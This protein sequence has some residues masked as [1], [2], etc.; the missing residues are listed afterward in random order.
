MKQILQRMKVLFSIIC[1]IRL[2]MLLL[3]KWSLMSNVRYF[4]FKCLQW[5]TFSNMVCLLVDLSQRPNIESILEFES[6]QLYVALFTLD[7][8]QIKLSLRAVARKF[9][10]PTDIHLSSRY[11]I[12]KFHLK[13]VFHDTTQ[14][15]GTLSLQR[16]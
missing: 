11:Q 8:Q 16:G 9:W 15:H 5:Q 7:L 13:T 2:S 14:K 1:I 10:F 6:R 12:R 3:K 4:T